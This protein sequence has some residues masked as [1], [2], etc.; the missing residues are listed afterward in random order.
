M[1]EIMAEQVQELE[2]KFEPRTIEHLGLR[3]YSTL[4]PALAE[5]V[6]NSYDAD[7]S[8]VAIKLIENAG[9]LQKIE[10]QDDGEGLSYDDINGKFLVIGRN[11]RTDGDK[12]SPKFG[13]YPTGK[14]GLGKL[15]LFGVS[16]VIRIET[17]KDNLKNEF[18][19]DWD[20]LLK[21]TGT[22]K[23]KTTKRN[24]ATTKANGTTITMEKLKRA[25]VFNASALAD[26][27]SRMFIFDDNFALTIESSSGDRIAIDNLRKYST[28]KKEFEWLIET[29][30]YIPTGSK[31]VGKIKGVLI[32]S[33]KP[34]TPQ[35]GL[36]GITLFSRGKL[37]NA[38]EFFSS[39][40]S[41]HFYQYL[42]GWLTVNFIDELEE[43]VIS[44]NRQSINWEYPDMA[45]LR[46]FL[47]GV[48]S[49]VNT[50]WRKKRK[51]KKTK[52]LSTTT[53]IDTDKWLSTMSSDVKANTQQIIDAL[54][55]EDA[56]ETFAPVIKSL[57][58]LVPE[59]PYLH[60][61]HLHSLV[62]EKSKTYYE[63]Q[64]YYNAF[65]ESMKK[66]VDEVQNKS[67]IHNV[68][69]VDL[70]GKVFSAEKTILSVIGNYTKT[71]GD[72]FSDKTIKNVQS[73]Q[74]H[75]SQGVFSGGRNPIAHEENEVLKTS[76]LFSESDW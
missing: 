8:K 18:I 28:I 46:D 70:M 1:E 48:I 34:L 45:E 60:W 54:G 4:P 75:L 27:L 16:A 15:A 47:S 37:V 41:S 49:Q 44:T 7:A 52:E 17:I 24:Q 51:D 29:E 64:D 57:H 12:P 38:P 33:E 3:M 42:T 32:T 68:D 19:L 63:N 61:R 72:A 20:D 71:N 59:Y 65:F 25:T 5:L 69:G 23:P 58:A 76:D 10:I 67:G 13:R 21:A 31:Y 73:G 22:Y 53:G 62:Q 56:I 55:G 43:D 50:E 74:M 36:R 6:S 11:R 9:L 39:S 2:M 26:S 66:Y 30:P 14:K 40:T 35:S